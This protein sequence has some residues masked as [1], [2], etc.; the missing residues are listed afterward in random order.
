MYQSTQ[1]AV[2]NSTSLA[3]KGRAFRSLDTLIVRQGAEQVLYGSALA[4][5]A[6]TQP[7]ASDAD[8]PVTEIARTAV[9]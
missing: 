3:V 6:A 4:L 2:A 7:W 8:M 9:H 5:A 1:P